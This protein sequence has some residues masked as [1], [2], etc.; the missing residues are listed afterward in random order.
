MDDLGKDPM[1]SLEKLEQA[2]AATGSIEPEDEQTARML[3]LLQLAQPMIGGLIPDTPQ[4]L[5]A[6]L[7]G[8]SEW[9]LGLVSD[10][11]VLAPE[12]GDAMKHVSGAKEQVAAGN[13][14]V[15]GVVAGMPR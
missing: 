6:Q 1:N 10:N 13:G 11:I 14:Y 12:I 15:D 3:Q 9:L 4:A 5:D 2:L 8:I 7:L